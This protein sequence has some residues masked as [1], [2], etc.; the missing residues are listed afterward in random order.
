MSGAQLSRIENAVQPYTQ[1]FLESAAV[2][3]KTD[4]FSLLFRHPD[5]TDSLLS[6]IARSISDR[7]PNH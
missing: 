2:V 4:E 7:R 5:N 1:D 6:V 3:Y